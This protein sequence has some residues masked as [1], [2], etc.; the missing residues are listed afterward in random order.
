[1]FLGALA[2]LVFFNGQKDG[3]HDNAGE[4]AENPG[5]GKLFGQAAFHRDKWR[6][7][8]IHGPCPATLSSP[9]K[10]PRSSSRPDIVVIGSFMQDL[11]WRTDRFPNPGETIVGVSSAGAGGKGSNQAIAAA[12]AGGSTLFIGAVG[13]D[14]F[15]KAAQAFYRAEG[16]PARLVEK[17]KAGT[18]TA[19]IIVDKT[20]QNQIVISLGANALLGV[21][22]MDLDAIA[23]AEV[24]VGQLES[25]QETTKKMLSFARENGATTVLNPAPMPAAFDRSILDAVDVVI[26]NENEFLALLGACAI[27]GPKTPEALVATADDALHALC[28]KVGVYTVIVTLGRHGV[29]V[30]EP[31]R[32]TRLKPH[33]VKAVDTTGAGDAF[34]GAFA[35]G[36]VRFEGIALAAARFGNAAAALSVT[37]PGTAASLPRLPEILSLIR[38]GKA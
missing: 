38:S 37:R 28:R 6:A 5:I 10:S 29:F 26:P 7:S 1:M 24:V 15:G 4:Y 34:V 31:D 12:R 36:L 19:A 3:A 11:C 17:P 13:K 20:G 33:K 27:D 14:V 32:C 16:I 35:A 2:A 30:S 25:N 9:V 18:G 23:G 8:C 22:D 21:R